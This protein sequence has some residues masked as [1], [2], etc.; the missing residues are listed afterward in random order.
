MFGLSDLVTKIIAGSLL[1][2]TIALGIATLIASHDASHFKKLYEQQVGLTA[3]ANAKL[4]ISN[5]SIATLQAALDSKNAESEARAKAYADS[6]AADAKTIADMD[7]RQK[8]DASRLDTL[9]RLAVSL[10]TNPACKA[11]AA[12]LA[13][14]E[15]L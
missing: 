14:L 2:S 9:K 4:S 12:L 13:N 6:K 15:G 1:A 5:A 8:A 10:P 11:P 3:S 7:A